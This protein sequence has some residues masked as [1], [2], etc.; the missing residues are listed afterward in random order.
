MVFMRESGL[1][2]DVVFSREM[3]VEGAGRLKNRVMGG[4]FAAMG[5]GKFRFLVRG[6]S[7]C[8]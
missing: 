5:A 7:N 3:V 6:L 4:R 8:R 1:K 2:S